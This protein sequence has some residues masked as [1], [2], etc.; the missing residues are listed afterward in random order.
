MNQKEFPLVSVFTFIYN[1][2]PNY[3]IESI[4]SII[5]NNYPNIQHIII[6]DCSPDKSCKEKVKEWIQDKNYD[7]EFYENPKNLGI[8]GNM[9]FALSK[10]KG[11]YYFACHDDWVKPG[12]ILR[13]VK[14][15]ESLNEEY[16]M[17]YSDLEIRDSN[18]QYINTLFN[19]YRNMNSGPEGNIHEQL[20]L[21]NFIQ[22][23]GALIRL[24]FH[25]KICD[26]NEN[27]VVE[28][29][30]MH[31]RIALKYKIKWDKEISAVY[32]FHH[33][34]LLNNIG[35][36]GYEQNLLSLQPFYRYSKTTKNHYLNYL[37]MCN[38]TFR[39]EKYTNWRNWYIERWKIKKDLFGFQC[40]LVAQFNL[41]SSWEHRLNKITKIIIKR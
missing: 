10:A 30:D 9:N 16:A 37:E 36:D 26:Y 32:R 27:L 2:N 14:I 38:R 1:T 7:C 21:G 12:K 6:D 28:D 23:A 5:N 4:Q 39:R 41:D 35:L 19:K 33:E 24:N 25:E 15:M 34:S 13:Q 17:V 8:S 20:F 18:Y 29:I 11:K 31:L 40:F 22:I 3:I